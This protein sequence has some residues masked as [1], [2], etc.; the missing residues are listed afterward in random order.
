MKEPKAGRLIVKIL[1]YSPIALVGGA[2]GVFM[3]L[4]PPLGLAILF[5]VCWPIAYWIAKYN[6]AKIKWANRDHPLETGVFAPWLQPQPEV[7]YGEF[8][9]EDRT[10]GR[11]ARGN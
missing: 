5:V 8:E 4:V 11:G 9:M 7:Y 1:L 6:E 10:R 2:A 3:L